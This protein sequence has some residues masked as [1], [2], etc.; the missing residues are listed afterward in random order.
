MSVFVVGGTG[1]I[2]RRLI[3]LLAG[4]GEEIVCMD[5]NPQT[6]D[7]SQ[8]GKQVRVVRGDISQFDDLMARITEAKP[9]RIVNLA[10]YI[11]S[12]LPPRVAFKLNVL[13]M[14]NCFEAARLA[15]VNRVVY[16]SSVAVSGEQKHYGERTVNEDDLRYGHVQYA[17]HKIFNEWQAQ[18]YREKHGM[19]ITTIRPANVTGPDKIFGSVDHVFIVTKPARG[20]PVTMPY[21]DAMR[22]PVH[23]DEIAEI[24]ARVVMKDK[25]EHA[26]YNTGGQ[27]I[28]LGEIADIVREFLP[29]AQISFDHDTGGRERSGNF[30]IDNSRVIEEFG[31]QYRP[32][33][34]RVLQIIN[35]VRAERGLPPLRDR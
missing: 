12:D 24:F 30:M 6:A 21:K 35:E 3:P 5:I 27:T 22:A 25:P 20:E 13:G 11:G 32:Y 29:D 19:E 7:Y 4:R 31:I 26:V 2:G 16:A 14:D 28:S 1:F 17:M 33:R 15:G 9:A 23:V 34:E 18:D 8:F 10:Y